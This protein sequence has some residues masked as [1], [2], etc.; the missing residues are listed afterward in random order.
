M[1]N[2]PSFAYLLLFLL[3]A[4]IPILYLLRW[5]SDGLIFRLFRS[6]SNPTTKISHATFKSKKQL[7][8]IPTVSII[9]PNNQQL[10]HLKRALVQIL[11]QSYEGRYEIIVVNQTKDEKT[12]I[13][14]NKIMNQY[15]NIRLLKLPQT[16]RHIEL[17]KIAITLGIKASRSEWV[18]IINPETIPISSKWLEHFVAY[19]TPQ[20]DFV[21]AY[22]NYYN[23]ETWV[24]RRAIFERI[25]TFNKMLDLWTNHNK[26]SGCFTSNIAIRKKT[27]LQKGG[28][29]ESLN[30]PFGEEAL[31][32][33]YHSNPLRTNILFDLN[34][35]LEESVPSLGD[36]TNQRI[37]TLETK[38]HMPFHSCL[39]DIQEFIH[40]L[41][42]YVQCLGISCYLSLR[43]FHD[44]KLKT[45][46]SL[47]FYAD[48]MFIVLL[49][50]Y[51]IGSFFFLQRS[52]KILQAPSYLGYIWIYDL[53]YPWHQLSIHIKR[54]KRRNLFNRK[55]L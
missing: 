20:F 2:T 51:I 22:L 26:V 17:R 11:S 14:F 32:A 13:Y 9:I 45:Y 33:A 49:S 24:C 5:H 42:V 1:I 39:Y 30:I 40:S 43:I 31:Y 28:F 18:I 7:S 52:L 47:F 34:L 12:E 37:H 23:D 38:R 8:I 15:D 21:S 46:D 53:M 54:F 55:Y 16:L 29:S 19:L 4:N 27:F 36:L 44:F 50:V 41:L 10:D 35:Q 6:Q 25:R 3:G 48:I